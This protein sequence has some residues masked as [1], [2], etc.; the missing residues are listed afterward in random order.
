MFM[1]VR[2]D[3]HVSEP[4]APPGR[5]ERRDHREQV[6]GPIALHLYGTQD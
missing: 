6:V 1:K 4:A 3:G 5:A 2:N